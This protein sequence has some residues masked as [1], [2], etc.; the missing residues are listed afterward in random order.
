VEAVVQV[1]H[2]VVRV[3]LAHLVLQ[4]VA[5]QAVLMGFV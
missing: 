5:E 1:E 2:Q 3:H 4:A